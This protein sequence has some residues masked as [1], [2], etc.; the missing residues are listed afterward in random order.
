MKFI[1]PSIKISVFI[2]LLLFFIYLVS[3]YFLFN[4]EGYS[5]NTDSTDIPDT[6]DTTKPKDSTKT[7][8]KDVVK[9]TTKDTVKDT[10]KDTVKDTTKDTTKDT[11][12][13]L[14]IDPSG[15]IFD[16]SGNFLLNTNK[17]TKIG[18]KVAN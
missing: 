14:S 16:I 8:T 11:I 7:N 5:N 1:F 4:Q 12:P 3:N 10:T 18:N 9:D 2:G 17:M 6:P 13:S 15:N